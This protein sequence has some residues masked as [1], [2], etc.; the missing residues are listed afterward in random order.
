MLLLGTHPGVGG[1][2]VPLK[3]GVALENR[4]GEDV[5]ADRP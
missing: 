4:T 2:T 1:G 5:V 3:D